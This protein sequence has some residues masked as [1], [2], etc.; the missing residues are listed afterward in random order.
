MFNFVGIY[1]VARITASKRKRASDDLEGGL[2]LVCCRAFT[3]CLK[4]TSDKRQ[5]QATSEQK[6]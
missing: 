1:G 3:P 6:G 2:I 5:A 4:L